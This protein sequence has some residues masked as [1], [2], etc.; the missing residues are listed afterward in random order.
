MTEI[1]RL[2]MHLSAML[3]GSV[4]D[5]VVDSSNEDSWSV[6]RVLPEW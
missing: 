2:E 5:L 6:S 3:I 1:Y 4:M